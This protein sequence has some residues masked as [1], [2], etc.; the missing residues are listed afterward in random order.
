MFKVLI[1]GGAGLSV[2]IRRGR[3]IMSGQKITINELFHKV[4]TLTETI[5]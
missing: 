5:Q 4:Q 2:Q 3:F 1:T